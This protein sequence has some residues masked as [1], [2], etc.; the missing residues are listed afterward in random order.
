MNRISKDIYFYKKL[1]RKQ[2]PHVPLSAFIKKRLSVNSIK[3][4]IVQTQKVREFL[5]YST[6]RRLDKYNPDNPVYP[7]RNYFT[8]NEEI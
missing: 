6:K 3:N 2:D 5:T 1:G 4:D 8:E 7:V